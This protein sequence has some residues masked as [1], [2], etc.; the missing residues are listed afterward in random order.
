MVL[1]GTLLFFHVHVDISPAAL[2]LDLPAI[3]CPNLI[4]LFFFFRKEKEN[5]IIQIYLLLYLKK[6]KKDK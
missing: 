4:I 2:L 6:K 3:S 5:L 1:A